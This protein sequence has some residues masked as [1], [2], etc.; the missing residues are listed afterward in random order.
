[1]RSSRTTPAADP[2]GRGRACAAPALLALGSLV[3]AIAC[4]GPDPTGPGG[5][6]SYATS[7]PVVARAEIAE[8]AASPEWIALGYWRRRAAGRGWESLADEP[9]FFLAPD[10]KHDPAAELLATLAAFRAPP[11][12]RVRLDLHP[13]CAFPA[14]FAFVVA[15][16]GE[17]AGDLPRVP[18]PELDAWRADLGPVQGVSLIFPEAYMNN[19][20]SM[21]GHTLLRL[22]R[23]PPDASEDR[24]D[25]LA[26]AV[27]F[28]ADTGDDGGALF[29]VKGLTGVYPGTFSLWPYYEKVKQYGDWESR[30]IW[31]YRLALT[32]DEIE[33]LLLHVFEM[34]RVR[35]D[36]YF[37]DENCSYQLLGLLEVARPGLA[38][39]DRFH[40]WAIPADTVRAVLAETGLAGEP[41]WR[42]SAATRI[43]ARAKSLPPA[44]R[45]LAPALASGAIAPDDPALAA[46]PDEERASLLL[47]AYD[48]LRLRA[49]ADTADADRPLSLALLRARQRTGVRGDPT[50]P[51]RRPAVSPDAGHA[52]ARVQA[53]AGVRDE[54]AFVELRARPAFHDLLD[55]PGG[56]LRGAEIDFL[57]AAVRLYPG[58]G[59]LD[60]HALTLLE[61]VSLAPRDALFHPI[62]WRVR[63]GL[64]TRLA[65]RSGGGFGDAWFWDLSGGAGFTSALGE[66]GLAYAFAE[67][68]AE[69]SPRLSPAL[70]VGPGAS[71][72]LLLGG[73]E[74]RWRTHLHARAVYLPLGDAH[75][76]LRVALEQALRLGPDLALELRV[77]G[78][79]DFGRSWLESGLFLRRWF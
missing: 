6:A 68:Q 53:G 58:H 72:G 31:E 10:G 16:L 62:S 48:L 67:A 13:Q 22:D 70:A 32:P 18:C 3:V 42:P 64:T 61:I 35:F 2:V 41:T 69:T 1:M 12:T 78:E 20:A 44:A 17:A 25:L 73:P 33:R 15:A 21:F 75:G 55:P 46:L 54:R 45:R 14:R 27:N 5:N 59:D 66:R 56:Y 28:A 37:F 9:E 60:L 74:D 49:K 24:R 51:A 79:R 36:Y 29:A 77:T 71:A 4:A 57:D 26:Y 63:T 43:A 65:P 50:P 19:P 38:L 52:P 34:R 11:E 30:D 23:A 47:L 39:R 7:V 8:L 40:G 76:A